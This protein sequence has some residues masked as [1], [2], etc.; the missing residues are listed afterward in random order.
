MC[1]SVWSFYQIQ[2]LFIKETFRWFKVKFCDFFLSVNY[3]YSRGTSSWN[4]Y[5][6]PFPLMSASLQLV[7]RPVFFLP[8]WNECFPQVKLDNGLPNKFISC[9]KA[10]GGENGWAHKFVFEAASALSIP[11][12]WERGSLS[13]VPSKTA[14]RQKGPR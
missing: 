4:Y 12:C 7:F 10:S 6:K 14:I 5:W 9:M 11:I 13:P 2:F 8:A 1:F 3:Q